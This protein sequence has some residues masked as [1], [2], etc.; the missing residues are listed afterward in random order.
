MGLVVRSDGGAGVEEGDGGG[1]KSGGVAY[2]GALEE[3]RGGDCA[4]GD[5]C[6]EAGFDDVCDCGGGRLIG[7]VGR[8][9]DAIGCKGIGEENAG[10]LMLA[11]HVEICMVSICEEWVKVGMSSILPF[12]VWG[13]CFQPA[14]GTV[15]SMEVFKVDTFC[16]AHLI[17]GLHYV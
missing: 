8:D 9:F 17:E 1:G 15:D 5:D 3:K 10:Y 2:A 11:E 16:I 12:A 4:G 14:A 6:E 13:D 7:C